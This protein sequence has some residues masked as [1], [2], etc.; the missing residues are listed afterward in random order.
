LRA[1]IASLAIVAV[2]SNWVF[3]HISYEELIGSV[4]YQFDRDAQSGKKPKFLFLKEGKAG[5]ISMVTY[6]DRYVKLQ[7]NGLNESFLDLKNDDDVLLVETL[8]GLVPYF[9]HDDPKSAFV[10]GFGGG[11]TTRALTMTKLQSIKVVELEPAV[12]EAGRAIVKGEIPALKDPRV[13]LEYN[14][15]RNTLLIENKHYD[16]IAAQPSHPWLAR[17]SNVFTREFFQIV[18]SRLN[19]G[20]IYGQWVNLFNMDATT[21]RS[22]LKAFFDVFPHGMTF[23]NLDSGDLI[24][25]GAEKELI[26]NYEQ[27]AK[28]MSEPRIKKALNWHGIYQPRDLLWY[29]SLSRNEAVK[30]AGTI[31]ANSDTNILSEVRLSALDGDGKGEENP[32]KFIRHNYTFD[33]LPYLDKDIP[34]RLYDLADYFFEWKAPRIA[35]KAA[36]QL[37]KIDPVL[38]RGIEYEKLW[39]EHDYDAAFKLFAKYAQWPDR[40]YQQQAFAL[41]QLKRYAE[42]ERAAQKV[43]DNS[44]RHSTLAQ[45]LYIQENW[46]QLAAIKPQGDEERKWQLTGLAQINIEAAGAAMES[47][48]PNITPEIP[49]LRVMVRYYSYR[50]DK[51]ALERYTRKLLKKIDDQI[52]RLSDLAYDAVNDKRFESA[53]RLLVQIKALNPSWN[54]LDDLRGKVEALQKSQTGQS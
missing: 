41:A 26:F 23:T 18:K 29:F 39:R 54:K 31:E 48:L 49:Q 46:Q 11:I 28:R 30:A 5:V 22:I 4:Q 37:E 8:L 51:D 38:A 1:A 34:N 47:L 20:G 21:L 2:L 53:Q 45:L 35:L 27:I 10:V 19:P 42:A 43:H 33:V 36:K 24:M 9:L 3:P 16:I 12:I 15:A 17:A 6:N 14:D 7:N 13:T 40:T 50:N 25:F 44:L 32:Y 52:A